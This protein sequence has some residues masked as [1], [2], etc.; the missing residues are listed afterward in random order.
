VKTFTFDHGL[1][2]CHRIDRQHSRVGDL[3]IKSAVWVILMCVL[4]GCAL[5]DARTALTAQRSLIGWSE[6]D[7]ESCLGAPDQHSTFGD[8]DIL[9]YIGN[10]T[11]N[12]GARGAGVAC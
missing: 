4:F 11:S 6:V 1:S 5:Q 2:K 10:S 7:L 12:K 3:M 8:I 9:T